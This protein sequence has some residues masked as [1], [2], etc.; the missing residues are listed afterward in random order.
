MTQ[1]WVRTVLGFLSATAMCLVLTVSTTGS[2]GASAPKGTTL[3]IGIIETQTGAAGATGKNVAGTDTLTAWVNWENA[4]GGVSGHPVKLIALNDNDDPAQAQSDIATLQADHVLAIVGQDAAGTEPTWPTA[5]NA[6]GI[7]VIGGAFYSLDPLTYPLFYPATT[8]VISN[9]W[10]E[11]YAAKEA[12]KHPK[13]A[14]LLCNN[15]SVCEGAVPLNNAAAKELN[16]PIVF[17]ETAS[18]TAVSYTPQCLAMKAS[19]ANVIDPQGVNDELLVRNCA[20]Q[21]YHP[22]VITENYDTTPTQI[23]QSDGV[24]AGLVGPAP[25]FPGFEKFP[26]TKLYWQI[27]QK[28]YPTYLPGGNE[29]NSGTL[30]ITTDTFVA[31]QAFAKA[32]QFADVPADKTVTRAELE[33]G[34]SMFHDQTLGGISPP[35]TYG[36]GTTTKNSQVL[37]FYLFKTIKNSPYYQTIPPNSMKEYCQP[38]SS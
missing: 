27:L 32:I 34:L 20:Q 4:H 1:R 7:P 10:G 15:S 16:I 37:C 30:Q 33:A 14:S 13:V 8:T 24:L 38:S 36:N 31:A 18:D 35:L 26:A 17:N 11:I 2:A 6:D 5:I 29:Y 21:G 3:L 23:K 9:V 28:Y 25:A 12:V 19:G 22:I